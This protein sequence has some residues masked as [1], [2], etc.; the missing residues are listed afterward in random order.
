MINLKWL[1]G[2]WSKRKSSKKLNLDR[3]QALK[4]A[5]EYV[6]KRGLDWTVNLNETSEILEKTLIEL[7]EYWCF[8]THTYNMN[9]M[10]AEDTLNAFTYLI[11]KVTGE[12]ILAIDPKYN[13]LL[14]RINVE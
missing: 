6:N 5:R 3:E 13:E 14:Q 7:E 1:Y 2:F 10:R 4:I 11:S 12:I 8:K 9:P